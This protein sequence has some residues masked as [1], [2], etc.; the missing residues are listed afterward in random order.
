MIAE[1]KKEKKLKLI[2]VD[3]RLDLSKKHFLEQIEEDYI[4]RYAP[5]PKLEFQQFKAPGRMP[6]N[7]FPKQL[8]PEVKDEEGMIQEVVE[9]MTR[10]PAIPEEK[11][12]RIGHIFKKYKD[13]V[14]KHNTNT[15]V[16][17]LGIILNCEF[18]RYLKIVDH[19][20]DE[21][22][23]NE[24]GF[25]IGI[26]II[27][28]YMK[29]NIATTSDDLSKIVFSRAGNL[30]AD[31]LIKSAQGFNSLKLLTELVPRSH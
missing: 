5:S 3:Q 20:Y 2:S 27:A 1:E 25:E 23:C 29:S 4:R 24:D 16:Q 15:L 7:K 12:D 13:F 31:R 21:K 9:S 19:C 28:L 26:S 14:K 8:I 22:F 10:K 18:Q 6:R 11:L 30:I 17:N